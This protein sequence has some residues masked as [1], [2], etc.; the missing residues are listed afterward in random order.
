MSKRLLLT[1]LLASAMVFGGC[2]AEKVN[3]GSAQETTKPEQSGDE[4]AAE[5]VTITHTLGE[6]V[7]PKNP[8]NV[9]VLEYGILDALDS[10]GVDVKG[11]A[12][13]G[14][15]PEYLSQYNDKD[16]YESVG[17][18][19]EID[20]EKVYE[21]EPDLIIIGGRLAEYYDELSR[22]APTVQLGVDASDYW[23]SFVENMTD[24]GKI[25]GKEAEVSEKLE[26]I[27]KQMDEVAQKAEE[28]GVNGLIAL[29]NGD[30]FSVYG[31]GSRFGLI[32]NELGIKPVDETIQ[33]STHGQNASFEYIVEQDPDYLFVVDRT[34]V[35]SSQQG[36]AAS[37]FDN[38][39]IRGTKAAKEGHI[40]Y[41]NPTIW[42]ASG[43]GFTST[44]MMVDE[45][46]SAL[47]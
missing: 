20:M 27:K 45:I 46:N 16:K 2:S 34:A 21:V 28:K 22:I 19:K 24:L 35:V 40:V 43:G 4:Q 12:M 29:T 10:L 5:T 36:S 42:Y 23:N 41:L 44:Q 13:G 3:S 25:F 31:K 47:Q 18:I 37:L 30:S 1:V 15:M 33:V 9:V 38:E 7:V 32:H 6:T 14:G 26:G 8:K 39:L 17:T 11:V